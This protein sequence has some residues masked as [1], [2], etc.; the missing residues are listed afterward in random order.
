VLNTLDSLGFQSFWVRVFLVVP[1]AVIGSLAVAWVFHE[2]IDAPM[3]HV[4]RRRSQ[5][6]ARLV[7]GLTSA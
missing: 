6:S 2:L 5:A 7:T 1:A 3:A 4:S